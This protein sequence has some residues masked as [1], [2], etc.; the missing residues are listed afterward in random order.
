MF[1]RSLPS[2]LPTAKRTTTTTTTTT[3]LQHQHHQLQHIFRKMCTTNAPIPFLLPTIPKYSIAVAQ[4]TSTADRDQ[5]LTNVA[6]I[7]KRIHDRNKEIQQQQ[8]LSQGSVIRFVFFP[9]GVD[10][11]GA[12]KELAFQLADEDFRVQGK[13]TRI[14]KYQELAKQYGLWLSLGGFHQKADSERIYNTHVII[15]DKGEIVSTYAKIHLFDVHIPNGP[16][17]TES[18]AVKP[19]ADV[20]TCDTPFG[21]FGLTICYDLRFPELYSTLVKKGCHIILIPSAFTK[22]TGEAHWHILMRAR[23]IETQCYIVA[24][25]QTGIH[26]PTRE[27]FGHSVVID[28]WGKLLA[29]IPYEVTNDFAVAEIDFH[30]LKKVREQMPVH[31]HRRVDL[32]DI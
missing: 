17:L 28:P 14:S 31:S 6:S 18:K 22:L 11:L 1:R 12:P 5:N 2:F 29:D 23:A 30:Y 21:R 7:L 4:I 27:S 19:G 10:S 8:H 13:N 32:Y 3:I 9:E 15:D 20:V 16:I 25:A 24:A 26:S